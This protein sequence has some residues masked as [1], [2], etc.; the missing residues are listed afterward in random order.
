LASITALVI[1]TIPIK[2]DAAITVAPRVAT[3]P[4][5]AVAKAVFA[6]DSA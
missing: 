6:I 2:C 4:V 1:Y 5:Y 3:R